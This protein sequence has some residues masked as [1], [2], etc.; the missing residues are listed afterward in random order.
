MKKYF[1]L[2]LVTLFFVFHMLG[3]AAFAAEVDEAVR[4]I[5]LNAVGDT[6][7][8]PIDEFLAGEKLFKGTCADCHNSG[9]TKPNPNIT[10]SGTDLAN[11]VPARNNLAGLVDYLNNPT[12]YDGEEPIA[13]FHPSTKSAGIYSEMRGLTQDDLKAISSYILIQAKVQPDKWGKGKYAY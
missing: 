13:L 9:S 8:I 11:A 5:P 12:S 7:V 4:T 10:L 1:W 6:V 2:P 3:G